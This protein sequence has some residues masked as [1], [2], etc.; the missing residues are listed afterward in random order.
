[1]ILLL[2]ALSQDVVAEALARPLLG[3]KTSMEELQ[4]YIDARIPRMPA[5]PSTGICWM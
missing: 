3:P 4:A 5:L 1:M 2:L